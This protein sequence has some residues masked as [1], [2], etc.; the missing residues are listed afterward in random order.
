MQLILK[1]ILLLIIATISLFLAGIM[2]YIIIIQ[3]TTFEISMMT[4]IGLSVL[5]F[6]SAWYHIKTLKFY[7]IGQ[8]KE[9]LQ[10]PSRAVKIFNIGFGGGLVLL[11]IWI[12]YLLFHRLGSSASFS[13][14]DDLLFIAFLLTPVSIGCFIFIEAYYFKG[15]LEKNKKRQQFLEIDNIKGEVN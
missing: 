15:L 3:N 14:S 2:F 12:F 11:S 8:K 4:T 7:R 6:L 1:I 9:I 13:S 5:G 10:E